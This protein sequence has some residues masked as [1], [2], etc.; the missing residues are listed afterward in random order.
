MYFWWSLC[1]LYLHACQVRVTV[2][3]SGLCCWVCMTSFEL[4]IRTELTKS[5]IHKLPSDSLFT[6]DVTFRT[7]KDWQYMRLNESG[8]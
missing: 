2:G 3:H 8:R 4:I 5:P 6:P 1:I 7:E